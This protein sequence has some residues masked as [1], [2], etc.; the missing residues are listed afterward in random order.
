MSQLDRSKN[1]VGARIVYW[2]PAGGGKT[3][4][5]EGV[6]R[7]IDP[8]DKLRVYRVADEDGNTRFFDLLPLEDFTF[9]PYRVRTRIFSVPGDHKAEAAR[10]VLLRGADAIVFVADSRASAEQANLDSLEALHECMNRLCM[11]PAGVPILWSFNRR[12]DDD[13]L[14]VSDLSKMLHCGSAPV[15]ETVAE[16]GRGI[17]ECF[18]DA[19]QA[20]M[21]VIAVRYGVGDSDKTSLLPQELLPQLARGGKTRFER[22]AIAP[23]RTL[24]VHVEATDGPIRAQAIEA[25][26]RMA[27]A[28]AEVDATNRMLQGRNDELMAINRVARSILS[29][30]DPDNLLVVLLDAVTE[31]LGVTHASCVVFDP[32]GEGDLRS[33]VHGFGRDPVLGMPEAEAREFFDLM[34][35]SDGPIPASDR[36]NPELL[37]TLRRVDRRVRR[38]LFQ[39]IRSTSGRTAGWLGIYSTEDEVPMTTQRLLFLS[40]ISRLAAL[41]LEKIT[42]VDRMRSTHARLEHQLDER[43]T[44]LEMANARIRALNRGLE[45]R[46]TERTRALEESN[47]SLRETRANAIHDARM[48]GMGHLAS[49]FARQI[50]EPAAVLAEGFSRMM[51]RLDELRA[52]I[53]SSGEEDPLVVIEGLERTIEESQAGARR[54]QALLQSLRRFAGESGDR[55]PVELNAALADAITMLE[56]RI[57]ESAELELR[58]G[59]LPEIEGDPLQLSQVILAVLENAVEAIE[60]TGRRGKLIV[61]TYASEGKLTLMVQDS[62]CGIEPGMVKQIFEPFVTTKED[63]PTAGV[64]LYCAFRAVHALGGTINVRSRVNEGTT[65]KVKIPATAPAAAEEEQASAAAGADDAASGQ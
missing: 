32:S 29:A 45:S 46:V 42:L 53:A 6:R 33:H 17:F 44:K 2:G 30:M 58:L 7:Y 57:Q 12:D 64:G 25:Q 14:T 38:G 40:S 20:M 13:V 59:N 23:E 9:G 16:E 62:G 22:D 31:Y 39:S 54:I 28:L 34:Q 60:R 10:E 65:V 55:A 1:I 21:R 4:T 26:I 43:T 36:H 5:L 48:S 35:N 49:A 11:D 27:E 19:F 61:S 51:S 15:H 18:I 50:G 63:D 37:Q 8:E 41:G 52:A 24:A 56:E 3:C 47:R